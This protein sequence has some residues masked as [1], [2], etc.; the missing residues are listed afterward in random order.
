MVIDSNSLELILRDYIAGMPE[1]PVSADMVYCQR[2]NAK[3]E[4]S[5]AVRVLAGAPQYLDADGGGADVFPVALLYQ[6]KATTS[7]TTLASARE[8]LD[9]LARAWKGQ[10]ITD[11]GNY[12]FDEVKIVNFTDIQTA[13]PNIVVYLQQMQVAVSYVETTPES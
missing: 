13:D 2:P 6:I 11:R 4:E 8:S 5:I 7:S 12:K 3:G 9:K 10:R 1:C